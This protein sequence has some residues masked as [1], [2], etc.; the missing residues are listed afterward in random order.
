MKNVL[1]PTD[2][3][4]NSINAINYALAF[5]KNTET[6]FFVLNVQKTSDYT[7]SDMM[8]SSASTTVYRAVLED[9]KTQLEKLIKKLR[10]NFA[11]KKYTFK[12]LVDFDIFTDAIRQAV[13]SNKIDLIIMGTNGAT[14]A[15]E[16][17]FGS[18]TLQV[19]RTID[20]PLITVPE[21]FHFSPIKS[22]LFSTQYQNYSFSKIKLL[23][24]IIALHNASLKIL[25]IKESGVKVIATETNTCLES[26]FEGI[27]FTLDT[28]TGIS[29]AV[30]IKS[31]EQLFPVE[32]HAIFVEK[33]SFLDRFLFG[34][35][36]PEI[37]YGSTI[38]LLIKTVA[39]EQFQF[40]RLI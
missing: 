17:I 2:F 28:L 18:N 23:K 9:N 34:S 31:F 14:G 27:D 35:N 16:A 13:N 24:Q 8:S 3:S 1:L 36:T 37:S 6:N 15:K 22:I 33:E 30:A 26:L 38:P 7:T 5:F 12:A 10:Q 11:S 21:G 29:S 20:C 19:I 40:F 39:K 25:D 32:L 4:E